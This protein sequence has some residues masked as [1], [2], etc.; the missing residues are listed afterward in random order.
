MQN[1]MQTAMLTKLKPYI[2]SIAAALFAGGLSCF[3]A[4]SNTYIYRYLEK[5]A[6]APPV[7]IFPI[8]ASFLYILMGI[9]SARIWLQRKNYAYEAMDALLSYS[10]QL[11]LNFFWTIIFFNMR[12]FLFSFIWLI[13]LWCAVLKMIFKF[14]VLDKTAAYLNI[15]YVLWVT[16]AGYLNFMIYILN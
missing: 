15:P 4:H 11:V 9:S 6:F 10:L 7:F 14:S 1:A 2:I 5:P 8:A 12:T 16:F 13:V 3:I